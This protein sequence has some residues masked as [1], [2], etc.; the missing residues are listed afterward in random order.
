MVR[1]LPD[2]LSFW[3]YLYSGEGFIRRK[4]QKINAENVFY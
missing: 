2:T 1:S 4:K 3:Q